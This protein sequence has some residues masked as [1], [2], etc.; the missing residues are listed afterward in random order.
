M[1]AVLY[2]TVVKYWYSTDDTG[3]REECADLFTIEKAKWMRASVWMTRKG[4]T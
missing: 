1:H 2:S 3:S 4:H